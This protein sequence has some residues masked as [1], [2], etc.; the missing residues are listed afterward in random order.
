M[1]VIGCV[2]VLQVVTGLG[3]VHQFVDALHES[4]ARL[5]W[6]GGGGGGY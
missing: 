2:V 5:V 6:E 4:E 1:H 3:T